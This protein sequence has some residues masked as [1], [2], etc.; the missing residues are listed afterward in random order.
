MIELF[1]AL[2]TYAIADSNEFTT[3]IGGR[4]DFGQAKQGQGTPYSV[5]NGLP[6][7]PVDTFDAKINEGT[8]QFNLFADDFETAMQLAKKCLARFDGVTLTVSGHENV[9][10]QRDLVTPPYKA[11]IEPKTPWQS[12]VAFNFLIQE[13]T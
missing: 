6:L 2:Y 1:N 5:Y 10:L 3:A 4:L 9:R 8:I 12:V 7:I 11:D 13:T